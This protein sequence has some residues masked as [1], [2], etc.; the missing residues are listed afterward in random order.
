A[1]RNRELFLL[2]VLAIAIGVAW[3]T[4]T[5]GLSI[6]LGAF[7]AGVVIA[8]T[9]FAHHASSDVG[10]FRDAF[11]SLFFLSIGMLLDPAVLVERPGAVLGAAIAVVVGKL[12][13]GTAAAM[14]LGMP[15]RV[16]LLVG[17]A[18]AQVGEFSFVLLRA[19]QS[20]GLVAAP[21][22]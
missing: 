9:D 22:A 20:L 3:A 5:A 17:A 1:T 19:G 11:A 10:P 16:A 15:A 4:A 7:L 12:V 21:G 6:A 18:I 2:S 13:L 14:L 8:D